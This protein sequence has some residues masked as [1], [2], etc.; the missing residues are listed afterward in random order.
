MNSFDPKDLGNYLMQLCPKVVKHPAYK[1][2]N[3]FFLKLNMRRRNV[4]NS[5]KHGLL[6]AVKDIPNIVC[7]VRYL[8][9][10]EMQSKSTRPSHVT[11]KP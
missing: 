1:Q 4:S 6:F 9:T 2:T 10:V 11:G 3:A 7:D 8:H 5:C